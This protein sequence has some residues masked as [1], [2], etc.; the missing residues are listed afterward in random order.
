MQIL[1]TFFVL[2]FS[3]STV[4]EELKIDY[5]ILGLAYTHFYIDN[6]VFETN[7]IKEKYYNS[8]EIQKTKIDDYLKVILLFVEKRDPTKII[9]NEYKKLLKIQI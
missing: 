5:K 9:E 6:S 7:C 1:I 4:S 3:F 2:F 8:S